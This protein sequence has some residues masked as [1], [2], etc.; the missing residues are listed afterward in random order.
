MKED[1][2]HSGL[3]TKAESRKPIP[4]RADDTPD[5]CIPLDAYYKAALDDNFHLGVLE[6]ND[7]ASFPKG[8]VDLARITFDVRGLIHLNGQQVQAISS[9]DYPENVTN[10]IIGRKAERL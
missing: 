9:I 8:T 2:G 5:Q 6:G 7:L 3:K 10:I 1:P 4:T